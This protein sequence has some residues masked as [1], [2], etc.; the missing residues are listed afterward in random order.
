MT[1]TAA[2]GSGNT[3]EFSA[4]FAIGVCNTA[5]T[6]SF[7]VTPATGTPSTVFR[8]DASGS[9]DNEQTAATLEV[10]WDWDNNGVYDTDWST[11]KTAG[12][13]YSAVALY[14]ARLQVRDSGVLTGETTRQVSV[15]S[16]PPPSQGSRLFLPL[17]LRNH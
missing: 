8:F 9:S 11:T 3:S 2:D 13:S 15:V 6:A 14:T 16:Q 7:T 4:P 1:A 17:V 5:P 12:H 10:R